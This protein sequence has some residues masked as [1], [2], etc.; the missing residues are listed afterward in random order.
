MR[1]AQETVTIDDSSE[2]EASESTSNPGSDGDCQAEESVAK[3][4]RTEDSSDNVLFV[5][6]RG[7]DKIHVLRGQSDRSILEQV[8]SCGRAL[9]DAYTRID[10]LSD[11]QDRCAVCFRNWPRP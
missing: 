10:V 2:D 6:H 9:T 7:S 8:L 11:G 4:P 1:I 3:K 5:R